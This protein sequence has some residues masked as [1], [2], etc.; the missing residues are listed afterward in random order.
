MALNTI[1]SFSFS[2]FLINGKV[3]IPLLV[4][5]VS[6]A[7]CLSAGIWLQ[8]MA[9]IAISHILTVDPSYAN[10]PKIGREFW[11]LLWS[12]IAV[13]VLS[14]IFALV[15]LPRV[16]KRKRESQEARRR[17]ANRLTLASVPPAYSTLNFQ[18]QEKSE[19]LQQTE[20]ADNKL[21]QQTSSRV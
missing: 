12:A 10:D 16:L 3:T 18:S 14:F 17:I 5:G 6:A 9:H 7:L 4:I 1:G 8:E 21:S 13:T 15:Q 11:A 2:T 20:A 19:Q